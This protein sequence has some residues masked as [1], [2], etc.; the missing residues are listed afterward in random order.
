MKCC[1]FPTQSCLDVTV[2]EA[3]AV[4]E[5]TCRHSYGVAGPSPQRGATWLEFVHQACDGLE[6]GGHALVRDEAALTLILPRVSHEAGERLVRGYAKPYRALGYRECRSHRTKRRVGAIFVVRNGL[7]IL[8]ILLF[9][10]TH[11]HIQYVVDGHCT[12]V[13][14]VNLVIVIED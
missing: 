9:A 1:A 8:V 6:V 2:G 12:D 3:L 13:G 14:D 7:S 5:V 11:I 10:V 4:E